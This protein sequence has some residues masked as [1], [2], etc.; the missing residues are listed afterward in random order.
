LLRWLWKGALALV[1]AVA[2][3][4]GAGLGYRAW[5]Q[6][7][8]EA[9]MRIATTNGIDDASFV[10][11]GGMQQWVTIR[12]HDRN[13][14]VLLVLHGG[15]GVP[16]G[17]LAFLSWEKEYTVAHWHQPG[18]GR[19]FLA[20]GRALPPDLTIERVVEDG[21]ELTKWLLRRLDKDKIIVL[22]ESW[23]SVLGVQMV[24]ARPDLFSAYVGTGQIVAPQEG[25]AIAYDSVL[26]KARQ[27]G[28]SVAIAELEAIGAPPYDAIAE[29]AVQRKWAVQYELGHSLA[30]EGL[31]EVVAPRTTLAELYYGEAAFFASSRHFFGATMAGPLMQLDLRRMGLDYA[32]PMF[33]IQGLNDDFTP[34][35]LGRAWLESISAPQKAFVPIENVGHFTLPDRSDEFLQFLR[36]R[37]R[38]LA[39]PPSTER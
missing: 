25:E 24:R 23:G 18:A 12:G 39:S 16:M 14:P 6:H 1:I 5:R 34:A 8:G 22:G 35:E 19:T 27:R 10:E 15:P 4:V 31:P 11:L 30:A 36:E 37:V 38:P 26:A 33:V 2:L 20:A 28:D 7:E 21:I 3:A 29:T 32:V 13:N 9:L 17:T